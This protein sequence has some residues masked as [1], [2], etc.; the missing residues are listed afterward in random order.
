MN[1]TKIKKI[2][3]KLIVW[4]TIAIGVLLLGVFIATAI[5]D[6]VVNKKLGGS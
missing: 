4:I 2:M 1:E 6:Y 5:G 3:W